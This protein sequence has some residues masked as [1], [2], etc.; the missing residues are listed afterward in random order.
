MSALTG[1][2]PNLV[3]LSVSVLRSTIPVGSPWI[4]VTVVAAAL[5]LT[6]A[7][8][9]LPAGAVLRGRPGDTAAVRQ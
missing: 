5:G 1:T 9:L 3:P 2:A 7:T 4:L 6:L 8:T